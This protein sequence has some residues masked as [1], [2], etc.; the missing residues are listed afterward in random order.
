M[1]KIATPLL[2]ALVLALMSSFAKSGYRTQSSSISTE[3]VVKK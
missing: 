1:R 2:I 3:Q